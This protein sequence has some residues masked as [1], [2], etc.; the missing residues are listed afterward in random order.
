M[1]DQILSFDLPDQEPIQIKQR[2][3][4]FFFVQRDGCEVKIRQREKLK[5]L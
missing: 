3:N 1:V 5:I 2:Q 4:Q